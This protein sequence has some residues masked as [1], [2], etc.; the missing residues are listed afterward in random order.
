M[1]KL[2]EEGTNKQLDY[3]L[4]IGPSTVPQKGDE[5]LFVDGRFGVTHRCLIFDGAGVVTKILLYVTK[6]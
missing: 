1:F 5:L 4:N 3:K 6:L 2:I